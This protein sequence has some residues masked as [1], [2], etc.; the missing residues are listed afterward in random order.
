MRFALFATTALTLALPAAAQDSY[1]HLFGGFSS[2]QDPNFTGEVTPP[3]GQ[4]SVEATFDTGYT[5]GAAF[6]RSLPALS[7]GAATVRGEVELS[8]SRHGFGLRPR[9]AVG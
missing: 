4:Q 1:V 5:I 8:Y 6:G 9:R 7:F 2:L 3:G